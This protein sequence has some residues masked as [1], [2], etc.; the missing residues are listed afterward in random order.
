MS[1]NIKDNKQTIK[2]LRKFIVSQLKESSW[3]GSTYFFYNRYLTFNKPEDSSGVWKIQLKFGNYDSNFIDVSDFINPFYFWFLRTFYVNS[4]IKNSEKNK[5]ESQ[6]A[7]AAKK[8][9]EKNK[10][11]LRDKKLENLLND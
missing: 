2:Y 4:S 10:D 11:V 7:N 9:F 5:K 1:E 8:F 6:I 3:E